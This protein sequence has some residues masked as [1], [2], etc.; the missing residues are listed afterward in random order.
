M[1]V[2]FVLLWMIFF[3]IVDDFVLQAPCLSS[4]KQKSYWEKNAPE[5]LYEHDYI[6][7][8]IVH[9]FSWSF[10]IMLPIAYSRGFVIGVD[11]A[12]MFVINTALHAFTDNCKANWKTINLIHDQIVHIFQIVFTFIVLVQ[13]GVGTYENRTVYL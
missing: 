9:S 2:V 6:W 12:V 10:M 5:K 1:N 11:F 7:A 4:L 8:L 3:H 13:R